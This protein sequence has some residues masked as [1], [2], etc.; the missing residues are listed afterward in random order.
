MITFSAIRL[1]LLAMI[2]VFLNGCSSTNQNNNLT[3]VVEDYYNVY[4]HRSDFER[5]MAFYADNA[6]FEDIIYGNNFKDKTEIKN[7]LDW[8]KGEFRRLSGESILTV[9]K[10]V[11]KQ[12]TA[13]TEGYFHKFSYDGQELGPWLFVIV[14]EFDSNHKIIKQ[15]D[16][17]NY[18]PRDNFLGG[19]NMN[20]QL[21]K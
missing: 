21:I 19:K 5:L 3:Q 1:F 8:N 20:E 7:F 18:T 4:S 2:F 11:V 9:T 14:Q 12:N 16:W 6:Q 15:T 13:I 17:I 10:Q